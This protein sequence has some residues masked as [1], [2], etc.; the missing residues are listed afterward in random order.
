MMFNPEDYLARLTA[1]LTEAYGAR[2][3]YVGL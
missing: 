2:L 3:I 1:R